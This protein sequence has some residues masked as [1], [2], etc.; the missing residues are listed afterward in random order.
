MLRYALLVVFALYA[1]TQVKKPSKWVGRF[2]VRLMNLSHSN[3]TDWGSTHIGEAQFLTW[4]P[5]CAFHFLRLTRRIP[6][7]IQRDAR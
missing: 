4:D 1:M 5:V 6:H 2:F 3:L 7:R